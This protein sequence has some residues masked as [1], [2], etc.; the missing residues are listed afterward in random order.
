MQLEYGSSQLIKFQSIG[1]TRTRDKLLGELSELNKQRRM[2]S[3]EEA[4]KNDCAELEGQLSVL[5]EEIVSMTFYCQSTCFTN[6]F[7]I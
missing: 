4:A 6:L 1:L 3:A 7:V 2:G 5:R